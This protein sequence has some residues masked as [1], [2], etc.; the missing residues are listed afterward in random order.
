M[1]SKNDLADALLDVRK[2]FRLLWGYHRR[3]RDIVELCSK[4]YPE[5]PASKQSFTVSPLSGRG[6]PLSAWWTWDCTPTVDWTFLFI[7]AA[8]GS[9]GKSRHM[10][11]I[12]FIADDAFEGSE[13]ADPDPEKLGSV[14]DAKSIIELTMCFAT[15]RSALDWS[16][17]WNSYELNEEQGAAHPLESSEGRSDQYFAYRKRI[18]MEEFEDEPGIRKIIADFRADALESLR[19]RAS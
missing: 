7:P 4:M 19:K 2:A 9:K 18:P 14:E 13:L 10:M 8:E 16:R 3:V 15:S 6:N 17:I 5:S 1:A 12:S 11:A